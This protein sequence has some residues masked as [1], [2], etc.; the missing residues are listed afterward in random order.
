MHD[1]ST[2]L[3]GLQLES[4]IV[5]VWLDEMGKGGECV[6]WHGQI[7]HVPGGERG[8]FNDVCEM[9]AFVEQYMLAMGIRFRRRYRVRRRVE[10]WLKRLVP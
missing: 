6:R 2:N 1:E 10:R 8:Y 5:K 3:I 7:T 9:T 4:F